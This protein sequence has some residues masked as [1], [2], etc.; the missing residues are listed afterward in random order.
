MQKLIDYINSISPITEHTVKEVGALFTF[1][2]IAKNDIFID[3]GVIAKKI[4][5][6]EEGVIRAY[7][8]NKRGQEY[9]KHFFK[10]PCFIGGY[11][12]LVTG[13]PN[14]IIQ[15]AM[16]D[17][18]LRE[19]NSSKLIALYD[20]HQ[21]LERMAR[22]LSERYF[23]QKEQREVEIVLLNAS[24]RY[25]IFKKEFSDLEQIIPQYHIASYLG[26]TPTQLSRVRQKLSK[27]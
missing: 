9:N 6:L 19:A 7:F 20:K 22:I 17:C 2:Q 3:A 1:R 26:I 23:V 13:K 24:E 10:A 5:F 14:Q 8:R 12:S 18:K 25:L 16:T 4:G 15:Q 21:D 11:S 27:E